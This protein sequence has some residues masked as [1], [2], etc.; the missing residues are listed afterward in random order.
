MNNNCCIRQTDYGPNPCILRVEEMAEQN[1]NFRTAV[2]TGCHVQMTL[3]C[4]PP[5]EDIGWEMHPDTDQII[6]V[7]HGKAIVMM[8]SCKGRPEFQNEMCPG[9]AVFIPAG[10]W[11]N[12]MNPERCPLKLSSVYAPPRHPWGTVHQTK[13]DANKRENNASCQW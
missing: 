1:K 10:T 2:W 13:M 4:I 5:C 9:D 8:G 6:R 12:I 3:M 11:H 7:E